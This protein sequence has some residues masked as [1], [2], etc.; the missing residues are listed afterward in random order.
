MRERERE[1]VCVT[2]ISHIEERVLELSPSLRTEHG[3][4]RTVLVVPEKK[5]NTAGFILVSNGGFSPGRTRLDT[6]FRQTLNESV[7]APGGIKNHLLG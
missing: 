6:P 1:R 2:S 3:G 5:L 7:K 4:W